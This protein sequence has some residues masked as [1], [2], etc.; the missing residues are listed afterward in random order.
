[1]ITGL[2]VERYSANAA[3]EDMALYHT[4]VSIRDRLRS[5][6]VIEHPTVAGET[7][8][9]GHDDSRA[10]FLRDKLSWAVDQ[11]AVLFR[12][13]CSRKEA[14]KAWD[15]VFDSKVFMDRHEDDETE[16]QSNAGTSVA[17][18]PSG[19]GTAAS[20][21]IKGREEAATEKPVDKHGGGRYA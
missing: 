7:L 21:L 3:R 18:S 14:L 17:A 6:L 11:L 5:N 2:V 4:M 8:T 9:K 20:L 16:D 19:M 13:D 10:K 15:K 1:M 12:G